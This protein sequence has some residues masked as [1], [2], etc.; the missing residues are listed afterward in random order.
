MYRWNNSYQFI[1]VK[2]NVEGI[3]LYIGRTIHF[4]TDGIER[5]TE[6]ET[7]HFYTCVAIQLYR[8]KAEK[9]QMQ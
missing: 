9:T 5:Y 4:Y 1:Q 6:G 8:E 2:Q 3:N 7:I